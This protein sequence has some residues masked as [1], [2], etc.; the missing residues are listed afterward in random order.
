MRRVVLVLLFLLG[1]PACARERGDSGAVEMS[2]DQAF[3]PMTIT[4][5][6]GESVTWANAST[7]HHSVT[8]EEDS[9]PEGA[10]YFASGGASSEDDANDDISGGLLGPGESYSHT[11]DTPGTYRYYC[12][13]HRGAGMRGTIVVEEP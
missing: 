3:R 2:S 13:P 6:A 11:F 12:I 10:P 8:A 9:V 5:A 4:I 1:A 7:E